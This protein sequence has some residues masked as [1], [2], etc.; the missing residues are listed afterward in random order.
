MRETPE[1]SIQQ[2]YITLDSLKVG[3]EAMIQ[4][5]ESD[6]PTPINWL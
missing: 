4:H 5:S 2:L 3:G 1:L 6:S